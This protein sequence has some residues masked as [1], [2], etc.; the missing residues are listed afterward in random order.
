MLSKKSYLIF[1]R[2]LCLVL[3]LLFGSFSLH[4]QNKKKKASDANIIARGYNDVTTRNNYYF[5]ANNTYKEILNSVEDNYEVNYDEILP[6]Y[7][8]QNV[9]DFKS[10]S[11]DLES[12]IK[13]TSEV[14]QL[15]DNTRWKDN[16]YL[17]LGK[18]RYLSGDY[19]EALKTFQF[20]VTTM[21]EDVGKQKGKV[22]NKAIAKTN[23]SKEAAKAAAQ[24]KKEIAK[25]K[26]EIKAQFQKLKKDKE[27]EIAAK[28]KAKQKALDKKIKAKKKVIAMRQ[29]G[30]TPPQK[31][32]DIANGKSDEKEEEIAEKEE[33]K[34][35]KPKEEVEEPITY[36]V[37]TRS[38]KKEQKMAEAEAARELAALNDTLP[39]TA[40]EI[41]KYNDLSLWQKIRHKRSRS[42]AIVWMAKSYLALGEFENAQSMLE[43]AEALPKLTRKQ[44]L[45][46]FAGEAYYYIES[47]R[48]ENAIE[49]L[50]NAILYSKKKEKSKY[51]FVKAQLQ[52]RLN[53]FQNAVDTYQEIA[54]GKA[55]YEMKFYANM[56]TASIYENEQISDI[57]T[58]IAFLTKMLKDGA[59]R[60]FRDQIHYSLASIYAKNNDLELTKEHLQSSITN[61]RNNPLQ[62]GLS[63]KELGEVYLIEENYTAS[64]LFFDSAVAIIPN[65]YE[66]FDKIKFK[67]ETIGLIA[68]QAA[69]ISEQDSLLMLSKFSDADMELYLAEL[70]KQNRG[71]NISKKRKQTS[72]TDFIDEAVAATPGATGFNTGEWYFYNAGLKA[73][74][75]KTFKDVW[76]EFALEPNWRRGE[77]SAQFEIADDDERLNINPFQ[78]QEEEEKAPVKKELKIPKT[79]AEIAEANQKLYDAH[80]ELAKLFRNQLEINGE[81]KQSFEAIANKYPSFKSIDRVYY[82]LYLIYTDEGDLARAEYFKNILQKE[83]PVSQYAVAFNTTYTFDRDGEQKRPDPVGIEKLYVST[84]ASFQ[85]GAYQEVIDRRAEAFATYRENALMPKFDFLEALS[86]GHLDSITVLKAKLTNIITQYPNHEVEKKAKEYLA[87]LN[88]KEN[89]INVPLD[90][91][92]IETDSGAIELVTVYTNEESTNIF[93]MIILKNKND[94]IRTMIQVLEQYN[95][96][97][98]D[99]RKLRVSN[100]FLDK[101][102][103]MILVKRFREKS[104]AIEYLDDLNKSMEE[105]F[106][107]NAKNLELLMISQENFRI[108]FTSKQIEDYRNFFKQ[109]YNQ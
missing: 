25:K 31:L 74:G 68:K 13:R 104:T 82:Y 40:K 81:A 39:M 105:V 73:Q 2:T 46:I 23:K 38:D 59:N 55:N 69:I 75:L 96:N 90:T 47:N 33:E 54:K 53:N 89:E 103:P 42:E 62:K 10:F 92:L 83:Y 102:T 99:A 48:Y 49:S 56:K 8:H 78:K 72:V 84:Y 95:L 19:D 87:Y 41:K 63:F 3:V 26:A 15:H 17:L 88:Q 98:F 93:A 66:A 44:R 101:D 109:T 7:F 60:E 30:K 52:E 64:K 79:D 70:E 1:S 37:T 28:N 21:K 85:E 6:I 43:Y 45:E 100:A 71:T 34:E 5:N 35:K 50:D 65:T 107:D 4:A 12:I 36:K 91:T 9:E 16:V 106:G 51:K 97:K 58:Q 67:G 80:Y 108:L 94:D 14:M 29:K 61:S 24:R 77:K 27:K 76:G 57:E 32:V 11:G 20:V 22:D 86:Y 18:A